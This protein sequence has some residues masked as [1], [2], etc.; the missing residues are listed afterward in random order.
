MSVT[1]HKGVP[2][3]DA[4]TAIKDDDTKV[5]YIIQVH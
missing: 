1:T 5:S 3:S 4:I 2:E